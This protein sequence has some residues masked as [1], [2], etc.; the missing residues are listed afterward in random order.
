MTNL[1]GPL[2]ELPFPQHNIILFDMRQG[3]FKF[4]F[5]SI[6][7]KNENRTCPNSI[8]PI[9]N[10]VETI[11]Q[12]GKRTTFW[13]NSH[14]YTDND[15]TGIFQPSPLLENAEDLPICLALS[16][17]KNNKHMVRI[18]NFLDHPYTLRQGSHVAKI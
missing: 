9:L 12:A 15:A 10:P 2:I 16:S 1:T 13:V 7:L 5:C 6:Q 3:I 18:S 4:T 8:E 14:F 11:L 17:T